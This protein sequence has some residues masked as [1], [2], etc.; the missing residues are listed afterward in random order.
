ME[1]NLKLIEEGLGE[2]SL[3]VREI[4]LRI[5]S[6]KTS[7]DDLKELKSQLEKATKAL[8]VYIETA[9]IIEARG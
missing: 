3:I 9:T 1:G 6:V 5:A 7:A 4:G 8:D 2:L